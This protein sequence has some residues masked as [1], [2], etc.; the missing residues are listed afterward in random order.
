MT[1]AQA[2]LNDVVNKANLVRDGAIKDALKVLQGEASD[3]QKAADKIN[4]AVVHPLIAAQDTYN[5]TV[6]RIMLASM[7]NISDIN[8]MTPPQPID[9]A[10]LDAAFETLEAARKTYDL[11]NGKAEV[12]Y[13]EAM[14]KANVKY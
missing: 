13:V 12:G 14:G 8:H 4:K 9:Q 6:G 3:A 11:A 2:A 1:T 10:A 5:E 7:G